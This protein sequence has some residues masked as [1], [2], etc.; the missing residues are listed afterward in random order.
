MNKFF[1]RSFPSG[2]LISSPQNADETVEGLARKIV[3]RVL[4][5]YHP[6]YIENCAREEPES[7]LGLVKRLEAKLK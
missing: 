1:G 6:D 4:S 3:D 2:I 7:L 5:V